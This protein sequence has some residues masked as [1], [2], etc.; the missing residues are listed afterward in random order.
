MI[1]GRPFV[2]RVKGFSEWGS[3]TVQIFE[4]HI[5]SGGG[6]VVAVATVG[7]LGLILKLLP[8]TVAPFFRADMLIVRV[9]LLC[10]EEFE[11]FWERIV[12]GSGC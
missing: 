9:V 8:I 11:L 12:L 4:V 5:G 10:F 1:L 6:A 3:L 2:V 7:S